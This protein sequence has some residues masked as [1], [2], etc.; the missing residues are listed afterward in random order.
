VKKPYSLSEIQVERSISKG[1]LV[2]AILVVEERERE[3]TSHPLAQPLRHKYLGVFPSD[4]PPL[5]TQH[6]KGLDIK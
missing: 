2:Y 6:L 5:I 4:L 1:K 3:A